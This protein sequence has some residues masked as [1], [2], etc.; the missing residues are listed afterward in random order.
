MSVYIIII[1]ITRDLW[2][3][4]LLHIKRNTK[5]LLGSVSVY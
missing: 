2:S 3:G 4:T 5:G 1:I